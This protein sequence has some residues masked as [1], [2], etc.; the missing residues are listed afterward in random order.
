[1]VMHVCLSF[2]PEVGNEIQGKE[3]DS[4]WTFEARY[5]G[6]GPGPALYPYTVMY[7]D[8]ATGER[9][10]EDKVSYAPFGE[11]I[12]EPALEIIGYTPDASEKTIVIQSEDNV[13][14]FLYDEVPSEEG[15]PGATVSEDPSEPGSK[16][17]SGKGVPTGHDLA[18]SNTTNLIYALLVGVCLLSICIIIIR[19]RSAIRDSEKS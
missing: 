3:M 19:I 1:M 5:L 9:L 16:D 2:P 18:D 11:E 15:E 6:D 4:L 10:V 17:S 12:T 13:I 8:D 7:I 14:V